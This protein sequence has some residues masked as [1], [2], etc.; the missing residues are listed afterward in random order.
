MSCL[1]APMR[2]EHY[3]TKKDQDKV[4][5]KN[6]KTLKLFGNCTHTHEIMICKLIYIY[7]YICKYQ[8]ISDHKMYMLY[9]LYV[10]NSCPIFSSSTDGLRNLQPPSFS[11]SLGSMGN[12]IPKLLSRMGPLKKKNMFPNDGHANF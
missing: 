11:G 2:L 1:Q 7:I 8:S 5:R 12:D 10:L 3:T 4:Q 6:M 9:D